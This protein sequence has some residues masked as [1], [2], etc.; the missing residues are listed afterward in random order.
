MKALLLQVY[1]SRAVDE[2]PDVRMKSLAVGRGDGE[3]ALQLLAG[4]LPGACVVFHSSIYS[5]CLYFPSFFIWSSLI[6][7]FLQSSQI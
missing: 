6:S 5:I 4:V 7:Y 3:A 1:G 2:V